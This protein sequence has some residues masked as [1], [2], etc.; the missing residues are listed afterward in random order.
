M[1][2]EHTS[3]NTKTGREDPPQTGEGGECRPVVFS[4][5]FAWFVFFFF[6]LEGKCSCLRI[7]KLKVKFLGRELSLT[8]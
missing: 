7:A 6:F 4:V 5:V 2:P 3:I 8:A 1:P